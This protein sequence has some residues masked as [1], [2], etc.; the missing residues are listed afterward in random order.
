MIDE[1]SG[2]FLVADDRGNLRFHIRLDQVDRFP[3]C[4]QLDAI[5]AALFEHLRLFQCDLLKHRGHHTVSL[6]FHIVQCCR[7]LIVFPF[8]FGK[9]LNGMDESVIVF[10]GHIH[11]FT[12]NLIKQPVIKMQGNICCPFP[13]QDMVCI[14]F[15]QKIYAPQPTDGRFHIRQFIRLAHDRFQRGSQSLLQ[16]VAL[17]QRFHPA[18][19]EKAQF[20]QGKFIQH[21]L[22]NFSDILRL[23]LSRIHRHHRHTVFFLQFC[24]LGLCAFAVGR[25]RI[26]QDD[27]GL[28]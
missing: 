22:Q 12:Q 2:L 21:L 1:F 6:S 9:H 19:K 3:L 28:A 24:P 15:F 4:P 18:G 8:Y 23:Q 13:W 26:E 5:T 25:C 20:P 7:D 17:L 11:R 27:K 14:D 10:N 16:P